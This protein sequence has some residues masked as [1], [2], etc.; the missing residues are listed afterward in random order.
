[1][2]SLFSMCVTL[3]VITGHASF[4]QL[5][6]PLPETRSRAAGAIIGDDF[7]LMG[8]DRETGGVRPREAYKYHIPT[9]TWSP[10]ADLPDIGVGL[11][12]VSN[13]QAAAVGTKIYLP[14]GWDGANSHDRMAIYDTVTDSW[15]LG[16]AM[17]STA[18]THSVTAVGTDVYILAGESRVGGVP[19][20]RFS[21][22]YDTVTGAYTQVP[23]TGSSFTHGPAGNYGGATSIDGKVVYVAGNVLAGGYEN[24]IFDPSTGVWDRIQTLGYYRVG[25]GLFNWNGRA[26]LVGGRTADFGQNLFGYFPTTLVTDGYPNF[27]GHWEAGP[28][29]NVGATMLAYAGNERWFVKVGGFNPESTRPSA[30]LDVVEVMA[31]PEPAAFAVLTIGLLGLIL[32]RNKT[33]CTY[34]RSEPD[35]RH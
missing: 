2:K 3:L 1:M 4:W 30:Y 31:V 23:A 25:H 10:I 14:G 6:T 11:G 17:P 16:P 35:K 8:G 33:R 20:P 26:Y 9:G 5:G 18:M 28:N 15:S 19:E 7:Y 22:R 32:R 13:L 12:G 27:F 24:L 34:S 29:L 21:Q